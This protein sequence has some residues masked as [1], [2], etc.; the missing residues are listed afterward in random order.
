M[1]RPCPKC[2]CPE[3]Y[4]LRT[5]RG[6]YRC[7]ACTHSFSETSGTLWHS[8]KIPPETRHQIL[9]AADTGA[10]ILSIS[11]S[12]GIQYKTVWNTI[13]KRAANG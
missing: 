8:P 13:K 4:A 12:L 2:G 1:T 5:R 6:V 10:S 9:E 3:S 7:K 11:K